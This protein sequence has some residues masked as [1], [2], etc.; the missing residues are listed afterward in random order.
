MLWRFG[1][2]ALPLLALLELGGHFYFARRA[3]RLEAWRDVRQVLVELKKP[4][5]LVVIAPSW[6][7]PVA[8]HAFGEA[9][10]PLEDV[11]R[12][13]E[14]RYLGAVQVSILG[15]TAPELSSWRVEDER[16]TDRFFFSVLRNPAPAKIRVDFVEAFAPERVT[17]NDRAARVE[18]CHWF[19]QAPVST[20]GLHGPVAFP[21][22]RFVC[23]GGEHRFVGVTIIDDEKYRPRRCIWAA[24]PARGELSVTFASVPLGR[25]IRGYAGLSYFL[26][27]DGR[28]P[29]VELAVRVGG[30]EIGRYVHHEERGWHGFE[31]PL[32]KYAGSLQDVEFRVRSEQAEQRHFCFHADSR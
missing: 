20:G 16:Q 9:L 13:D 5:Y 1:W 12:P 32:G 2:L 19:A 30:E 14:T 29:P 4:G 28:L 25:V 8:R 10:M 3:P 22:R 31:I 7:E 21:S 24:P 27:R 11:A 23:R 18:P 6:A 17:V 15:Q 26:F